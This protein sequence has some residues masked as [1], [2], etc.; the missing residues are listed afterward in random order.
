MVKK[1]SAFFGTGNVPG[2]ESDLTLK[3]MPG[4]QPDEIIRLKGKGLPLFRGSGR[5]DINIR[6]QVHI[7]ETLT[8]KERKLYEQLRKS[9]SSGK[10]A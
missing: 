6:V 7:P 1:R 5:G 10:K 8:K 2:F 3:I 9:D 4:T